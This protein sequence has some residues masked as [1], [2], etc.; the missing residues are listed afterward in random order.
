M[1]AKGLRGL[2]LGSRGTQRKIY[3]DGSGGGARCV[4]LPCILFNVSARRA[5][6]IKAVHCS[7]TE[8]LD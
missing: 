6:R 8:Q 5:S 2:Q 4:K 7:A 3:R 1:A